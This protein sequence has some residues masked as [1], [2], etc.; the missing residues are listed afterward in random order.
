MLIR[1]IKAVAT[2]DPTENPNDY[3]VKSYSRASGELQPFGEKAF[4]KIRS[5]GGMPRNEVYTNGYVTSIFIMKG[6]DPVFLLNLT[7]FYKGYSTTNVVVHTDH[8]GKGFAVP[9]Y[10]AVSKHYNLPLYSFGTHTPAG[11]RIWQTLAKQLPNRVSGVNIKTGELINYDQL[12]DGD[13][14]T[15][16]VLLPD[17]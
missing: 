12:Q 3:L 1:E 2:Y 10:I 17:K 6:T 7:K 9:T 14:N 8:T 11:D 5:I 13:F 16:A 15:R 4:I